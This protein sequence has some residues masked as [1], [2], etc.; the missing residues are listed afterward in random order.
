MVMNTIANSFSDY[1]KILNVL[2]KHKKN[3]K[4]FDNCGYP[5]CYVRYSQ[6]LSNNDRLVRATLTLCRMRRACWRIVPHCKWNRT[7]LRHAGA[8]P[9]YTI[10]DSDVRYN[11][12]CSVVYFYNPLAALDSS[13]IHTMCIDLSDSAYGPMFCVLSAR[14]ARRNAVST[15]KFRKVVRQQI[16][17][18]VVSA[19][20]CWM[21]QW[22]NY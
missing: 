5:R 16:W 13:L 6:F 1:K 10:Y 20:H 2:L 15:L 4:R 18:E 7:V 11:K 12:Q 21:Q 9:L 17:G 14:S 19:V 8:S 22:N 3:T